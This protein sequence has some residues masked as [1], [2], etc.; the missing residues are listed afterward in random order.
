MLDGLSHVA[1]IRLLAS[2]W[3]GTRPFPRTD[4]YDRHDILWGTEA[5]VALSTCLPLMN[6]EMMSTMPRRHCENVDYVE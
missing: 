6:R 5:L 3:T 1:N 4:I 2:D